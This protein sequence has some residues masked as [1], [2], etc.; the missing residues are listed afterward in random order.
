LCLILIACAAPRPVPFVATPQAEAPQA[1]TT[2]T[3]TIS[4]GITSTTRRLYAPLA[5]RFEE[6]YPEIQVELIELDA[7]IRPFFGTTVDVGTAR[8]V[9]STVDTAPSGAVGGAALPT[10]A[11]LDLRPLIDADAG[12]ARDDFFPGILDAAIRDDKLVM[13][14]FAQW[15]PL[16]SYNQELWAERGLAPPAPDWT[17]EDLLRAAEQLAHRRGDQQ[18][19]GFADIS[20]FLALR[21]ELLAAGVAADSLTAATFPW[22]EPQTAEALRRVVALTRSGAL[23]INPQGVPT[24]QQQQPAILN[25]Q[26]GIW[27]SSAT[28]PD[29]AQVM[30]WTPIFT[31]GQTLLPRPPAF[32]P[33]LYGY[34]ISAGTQHP[35]EAWRWIRFLS[36]QEVNEVWYPFTVPEVAPTRRSVAARSGYFEQFP[37]EVAVA[38]RAQLE[39]PVTAGVSERLPFRDPLRMAVEDAF[40]AVLN[41]GASPEQ[42]FAAAQTR[43]AGSLAELSAT[44][45]TAPTAGSFVVATP[46]AQAAPGDTPIVVGASPSLG[47]AVQQAS[48]QFNTS[49]A[50][51]VVTVRVDEQAASI[52]D[53]TLGADCVAAPG[54][55]TPDDI[56]ALLDLQPYLDLVGSE[57]GRIAPALLSPF[58]YDGQLLG[59]PL[60]VTLPTLGYQPDRFAQAGVAAPT[61]SWTPDDAL[62]TA[63]LLTDRQA[64]APRYGYASAGGDL[65]A[66]VRFW[67]ARSGARLGAI[68]DGQLIATL[69]DP[70]TASA[71]QVVVTL[72]RNTS[73]HTRLTGY[74]QDTLDMDRSGQTAIAQGQVGLWANQFS[75][76]IDSVGAVVLAPLGRSGWAA[77]DLQVSGLATKVVTRHADACWAWMQSVQRGWSVVS[78]GTTRPLRFPANSAARE[79]AAATLSPETAVLVAE[80]GAT[81]DSVEAPLTAVIPPGL[82]P[83]WFF[84][85]VDR[86]LQGGDLQQELADAQFLTEQYLACAQSG[87]AADD[88]ARQ[89]DPAYRG[90][91]PSRG[92]P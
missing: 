70:T 2:A 41:N 48:T 57:T 58:Q 60:D 30:E 75:A 39:Q 76:G 86:A 81:L 89:V 65:S 12:F 36:E 67:L 79:T 84:R 19:Y 52:A 29:S 33:D 74:S 50:E 87:E 25:G 35:E 9:L 1:A 83:Y 22:A 11:V 27:Y 85:A 55:P 73:P 43:L 6:K 90:F 68:R 69:T 92:S 66:D 32:T 42:A 91:G 18:V 31:M 63:Q 23:Y 40:F 17:W 51:I 4:F 56:P 53:L 15:I 62:A 38:L 49:Q 78:E 21:R 10:T 7:L 24:D 61:A 16:L 3:V 71:A 59:L 37:P 88:C 45:A 80:Y 8:R 64:A 5:A 28:S 72:L 46:V 54:P 26:V 13:L 20:P 44:A 47:Q 14:P 77:D 34:V 82:D